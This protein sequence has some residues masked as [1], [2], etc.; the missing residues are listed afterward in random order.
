LHGTLMRGTF[1][2]ISQR[3]VQQSLS[4]SADVQYKFIKAPAQY[5]Y[6]LKT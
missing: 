2:I 6:A 3:P 5:E 1:C 4:I